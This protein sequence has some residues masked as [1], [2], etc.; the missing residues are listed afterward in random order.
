VTR[1]RYGTS[2]TYTV[3]RND[4]KIIQQGTPLVNSRD[5]GI[6]IMRE[7]TKIHL[8]QA[9][10]AYEAGQTLTF[11]KINVNMQGI[12]NGREL[13]PWNQIGRLTTNN[14]IINIEKD[15]RVLKWS[16]VKAAD[17]PNLSVLIALVNYIVRGQ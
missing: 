3:Q 15:G 6:H 8:P 17:I 1:N 7:M 2:F 11:G 5:M 4:G 12:N 13:V 10:M 16:S 9:K 14:G